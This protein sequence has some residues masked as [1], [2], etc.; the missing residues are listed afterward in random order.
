MVEQN[1]IRVLMVDDQ[2][3]VRAGLATFLEAFDDLELVGEASNGAEAIRLCAELQPDV[4]LM[5]LVMPDVDGVAAP[6][7]IRQ[8][9]PEATQALIH[10]ATRAPSQSYSLTERELEVLALLAEGLTN[11]QIAERL[12]ISRS[13]VKSHVSNILSK[14]DVATRAEA[15]VL[16]LQ[17]KLIDR[18]S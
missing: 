16:A 5:D 10:A 4:V 2:A 9:H 11:S 6:R 17:N 13:T 12:V 15:V 1:R 14:L 7:A 3:V 8:S 18:Q